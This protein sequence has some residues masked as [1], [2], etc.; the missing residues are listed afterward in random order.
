MLHIQGFAVASTQ[1]IS[2]DSLAA[3]PTDLPRP[4][5]AE[6]LASSASTLGVSENDANYVRG[7]IQEA[8]GDKGAHPFV[9]TLHRS[10]KDSSDDLGNGE[11]EDGANP[12]EDEGSADQEG[13]AE[14][15]FQFP[16]VTLN[17]GSFSC[18]FLET[19]EKRAV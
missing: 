14:P 5:A 3:S 11:A 2:D 9:Q 7:S 19:T 17:V 6:E 16:E 18:S 12:G 1:V 8:D 15:P 10:A 4:H 13:D